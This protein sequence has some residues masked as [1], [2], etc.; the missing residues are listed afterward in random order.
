MKSHWPAPEHEQPVRRVQLRRHEK[1]P[2]LLEQ[3]WPW[4]RQ[5]LPT[6]TWFSWF[7]FLLSY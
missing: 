7:H 6:R 4:S 2:D 1:L 3:W 5:V